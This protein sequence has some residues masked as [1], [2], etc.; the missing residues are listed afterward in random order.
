MTQNAH[1]RLE[2]FEAMLISKHN[3]NC[4]G[5]KKSSTKTLG[6]ELIGYFL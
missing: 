3:S 2:Q 6:Y 4:T 1:N 5:L